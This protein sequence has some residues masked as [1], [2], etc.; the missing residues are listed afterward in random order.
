MPCRRA[1]VGAPI[2]T[3][4]PFTVIVPPSAGAT[5]KIASATSVRPEP[6]NPA[7]PS[8]SPERTSNVTPS[9]DPS[10]RRPSTLKAT[11]PGSLRHP[12]EE[13][14]QLPPD[15]V[16]DQRRLGDVRDRP[17]RDVLAVAEH[18]DAITQLEDL[19]EPMADEED[20]H[21]GGGQSP[22]L[23]KEAA[24]LVCRQRRG[25]FVHDQHADVTG[26]RLG[27]LD[28]LLRSHGEP[29]RDRTRVD[30]DL[31]LAAGSPRRGDAC[32]ASERTGHRPS[33]P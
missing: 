30:V 24:H 28:G 11:S 33:G 26:H 2:F 5:P 12:V 15:H 20:R 25:R 14:G 7:K 4:V 6:T 27:D 31:E 29:G 22:N 19:V 10:R 13:V 9:K 21:A 18:G 16:T 32:H 1:S 8:T 17:G 23:A 3:G